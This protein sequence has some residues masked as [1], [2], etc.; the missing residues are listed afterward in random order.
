MRV[1]S[2]ADVLRAHALVPNDPAVQAFCGVVGL[3]IDQ[4]GS[5]VV[6][7]PGL[8]AAWANHALASWCP[9]AGHVLAVHWLDRDGDAVPDPRYDEIEDLVGLLGDTCDP[10]AGPEWAIQTVMHV[11]AWGSLGQNHLWQD[12]FLPSRRELSALLWRWFPDL[13]ARNT[14]DM[15]WKKFFYKQ[16][17]ERAEL[18]ICKSPSC[19]VCSDYRMCF[20]PE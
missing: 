6:P 10:E 19:G 2:A 18:P 3:R 1:C 11:V 14:Q 12:L 13:A 20:G 17:C 4:A 5:D 15:K 16:L 8:P 9:G 7:L